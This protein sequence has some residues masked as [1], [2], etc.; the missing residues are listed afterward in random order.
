M[1]DVRIRTILS[2]AIG[3]E[4]V[5]FD[6]DHTQTLTNGTKHDKMEVVPENATAIKTLYDAT[7]DLAIWSKLAVFVDP[8][9]A[10]S[11]VRDV[12]IEVRVGT[13]VLAFTINRESPL[14]FSKQAAAIAFTGSATALASTINRIRAEN[15]N[16]VGTPAGTNDVKVRCVALA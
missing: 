14:I 3:G 8:D 2:A 6:G 7:T 10:E 11:A 13:T 9:D 16:A 4:T 5:R 15:N 12:A 1:A